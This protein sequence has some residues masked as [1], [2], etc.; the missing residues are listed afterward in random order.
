MAGREILE[1]GQLGQWIRPISSRGDESVWPSE[2]QY[3]G[4]AGY[5]KVLD[6]LKVPLLQA[7]PDGCQTE[8]WVLDA[9]KWWQKTG[10]S[11]WDVAASY[12]ENSRILFV[13]A[14][15]S[16]YGQNNEIPVTISE[17]LP[18][19]LTLIRVDEIEVRK[20]IPYEKVKLIG[21]FEYNGIEYAFDITDPVIESEY[22]DKELGYYTIDES[23]LCISLSKPNTKTNG[24]GLDYRYKLI[25]AVMPKPE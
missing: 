8:N 15:G 10:T 6:E 25:A 5:P 3:Y 19:S 4:N 24:D 14:G 2:Q 16:K 7:K 21:R 22:H 11:T 18:S 17:T 23:L 13:N 1:S 12:A 9:G 20:F